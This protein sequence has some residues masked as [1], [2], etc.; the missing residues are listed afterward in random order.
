[1]IYRFGDCEL[2]DR[3]YELRRAGVP[4]HLEPQAFE[5]L[6]YLV[7]H[8][9]RVVPRT[10]LIDQIWGS[11]FVTD[12]ALASRVKA[13][14]RAVGDSGRE[15]AVIRT[16]HGRGYQF[17][18]PVQ[19]LVREQAEPPAQPEGTPA[20]P[21]GPEAVVPVG[22]EAELGRLGELYELA[23]RGRRQ[24]VLVTG[25]PGIG[26]STLVEAFAGEVRRRPGGSPGGSV[27][28]SGARPSRTC[29][30]STRWTGCA[31]TTMRRWPRCPGWRRPGWS[32]C[33]RWSSP[34]IV[35]A[36]S[37]GRWAGRPSGCSGRRR[38]RWRPSPRPARWCWS[39]RTSTG[40]TPRPSTC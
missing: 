23:Q 17:L 3:T 2:D 37:G 16:V 35:A 15:Q 34:G 7:R 1:M 14:R 4:C 29:R 21:Q 19:E 40:P 30:S 33:R 18:A 5:V 31:G 38:R 39:S 32:R 11:R 9:D 22:R 20:L 13:V 24:V 27:S 25:E 8:R 28:S 12:S 10:E 26:K 6:A 36:W